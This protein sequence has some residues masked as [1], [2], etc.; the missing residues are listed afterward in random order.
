MS[1]DG[2]TVEA[3]G[4]LPFGAALS[5]EGVNFAVFS[6]NATAVTLILFES[7]TPDSARIE[8]PLNKRENKTGNMW[9]CF[10]K[11]LRAGACYLYRADGP[12]SPEKGLRFNRHKTLIDPYAK[13]L[14]DLP[15][16]NYLKG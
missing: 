12:Y 3:G 10:V 15:G 14:T 1:F 16:W 7:A 13:A 5:N 11:G 8:I 4:A 6:R 9:H 2:I